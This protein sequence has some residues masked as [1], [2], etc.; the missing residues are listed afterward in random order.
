[1]K[2]KCKYII[3]LIFNIFLSQDIIAPDLNSQELIE[4]LNSNYKTNNV[5]GYG[6][7]RDLMYSEIDIKP[8]SG[9]ATAEEYY[10]ETAPVLPND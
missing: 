2:N 10:R 6:P 5:L 4:Y 7:A 1:M 8:G 3:I 9:I